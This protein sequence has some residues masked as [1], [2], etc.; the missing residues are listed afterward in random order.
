MLPAGSPGRIAG[1]LVVHAAVGRSRAGSAQLPYDPAGRAFDLENLRA[2][3]ERRDDTLAAVHQLERIHEGV[4]LS[5]LAVRM[6][7]RVPGVP[8][9]QDRPVRGNVLDHRIEYALAC[10]AGGIAVPIRERTPVA[11]RFLIR[12]QEKVPLACDQLVMPIRIRKPDGLDSPDFLESLVQENDFS[13]PLILGAE[14]TVVRIHA[15]LR[16]PAEIHC[17]YT[18]VLIRLAVE[19]RHPMVVEDGQIRDPGTI[20]VPIDGR[21]HD[22]PVGEAGLLARDLGVRESSGMPW[23][24]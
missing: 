24:T 19:S 2:T 20:R 5:L 3:L 17:A 7:D 10:R 13:V 6:L 23:T 9:E 18:V 15:M 11:N 22:Q 1:N 14:S 8:F 12:H 21:R 4:F 16:M